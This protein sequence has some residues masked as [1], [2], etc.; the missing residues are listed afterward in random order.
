MNIVIGRAQENESDQLTLISFAA[1]RYWKYPEEYF[2]VWKNELTITKDYVDQNKV[3]VARNNGSAVGFI[4]IVEMKNDFGLG[5][6]LIQK[7]YWLDHIF[8][9]PPFIGRGV[10]IQ[11]IL[12]AKEVCKENNIECLYILSDPNAKGFYDRIGSQYIGEVPSN[13]KGRNVLLYIFSI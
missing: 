5:A 3:Y 11:L 8:V 2:D 1:K 4:S 10:G 13:I 7:G 9:Y 6:L 12:F